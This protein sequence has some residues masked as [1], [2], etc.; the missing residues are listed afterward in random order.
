MPPSAW[1]GW[2]WF[3]SKVEVEAAKDE[4]YCWSK[5]RAAQ[6]SSEVYS[7]CGGEGL[8]C[9]VLYRRRSLNFQYPH[10]VKLL[11]ILT[12]LWSDQLGVLHQPCTASVYKLLCNCQ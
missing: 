12:S 3:E 4:P 1:T 2:I 8:R 9:N 6:L 7:S 11:G 5:L 10:H